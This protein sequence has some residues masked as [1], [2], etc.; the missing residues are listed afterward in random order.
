MRYI[1]SARDPQ[2]DLYQHDDFYGAEVV[3][4]DSEDEALEATDT[5]KL[6]E[7]LHIAI[8]PVTTDT[9]LGWHDTLEAI[10]YAG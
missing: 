1:V 5:L 2:V 8:I 10:K 7:G 6:L 3:E 4:A 9:P